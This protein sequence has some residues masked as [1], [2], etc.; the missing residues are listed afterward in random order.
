[1]SHPANDALANQCEIDAIDE[2]GKIGVTEDVISSVKYKVVSYDDLI[3]IVA[4]RLY[5][6]YMERGRL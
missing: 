5:E 4:A 6:S 3:D 1:M 2:L